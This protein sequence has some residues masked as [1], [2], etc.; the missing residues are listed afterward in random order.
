MEDR[1]FMELL[2]WDVRERLGPEG[3]RKGRKG[4]AGEGRER[5][6]ANEE[7]GGIRGEGEGGRREGGCIIP[8]TIKYFTSRKKAGSFFTMV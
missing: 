5:E 2:T 7:A 3:G 1:F 6:E 8:P 4:G